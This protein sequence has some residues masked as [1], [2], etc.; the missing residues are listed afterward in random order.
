MNEKEFE[1]L[2][3]GFNWKFLKEMY[4]S[5]HNSVIGFISC[6]W[7]TKQKGFVFDGAPSPIVGMGRKGQINADLLLC[8]EEQPIIV[9]E[10][11]ST[12]KDYEKKLEHLK[13]YLDEKNGEKLDGYLG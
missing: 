6:E 1:T 3:K 9:V 7:I 12:I 4:G 8:R 10:V 5:T 11:E 13:R 2:I